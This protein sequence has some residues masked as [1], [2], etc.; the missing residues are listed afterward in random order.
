MTEV[1][2]FLRFMNYYHKSIPKYAHI[3]WPVNQLVSGDNAN[4]KTLVEWT[5]ECQQAYEQLKLLCSK[6][7]ILAYANYRKPFK[8]HSDANV[9]RLGA[10]L[11]QKQDNGTDYF[12][13]YAR[14]TLSI[15]ERSYG[16]HKLKFLALKW[17]V[18][19]RFHEYLYGGHFEV[20][21]DN[22][23][24]TYILTTA[25]LDVTGQRWVASFANYIFK[26][27]YKSG[28]LNVEADALSRIP[29]ENTQTNHLEPFDCDHNAT[30]KIRN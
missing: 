4:K 21:M 3:A 19:E 30:I 11:Y 28:K 2:R 12:I 16:A 27:F 8:L 23:P 15:S 26:I 14:Q 7:P 9:N 13:A 6:T 17:S 25:K 29:L 22:N 1:Q 24:L 10:V 20:Y 5:A 18:T